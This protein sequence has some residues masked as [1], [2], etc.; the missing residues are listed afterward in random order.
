MGANALTIFLLGV[1]RRIIFDHRMRLLRLNYLTIEGYQVLVVTA[2][3]DFLMMRAGM[4]NQS[5][6]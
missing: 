1:A 3:L 6:I 5:L 4:W 2:L